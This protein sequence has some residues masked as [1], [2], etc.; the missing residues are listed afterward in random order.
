MVCVPFGAGLGWRS[1]HSPQG[2][3][4]LLY[5]EEFSSSYCSFSCFSTF[6]S[7]HIYIYPYIHIYAHIYVHT[8]MSSCQISTHRLSVCVSVH[9]SIISPCI[10]ISIHP[11]MHLS[12]MQLCI[13]L[14]IKCNTSTHALTCADGYVLYTSIKIQ[15]GERSHARLSGNLCPYIHF[16]EV[17]IL[18]LMLF[19]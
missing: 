18:C 7:I 11:S 1:S 19:Y 5:S 12:A 3:E 16:S 14:S 15:H 9:L 8:H 2:A 4:V 17:E 10:H 6:L 13:H